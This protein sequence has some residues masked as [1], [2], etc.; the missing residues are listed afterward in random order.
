[1]KKLVL[2]QW[3]EKKRRKENIKFKI[4]FSLFD[5]NILSIYTLLLKTCY[6]S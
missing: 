1:M 3:K 4:L 2:I 5:I 6:F